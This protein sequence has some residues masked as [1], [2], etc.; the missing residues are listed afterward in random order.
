MISAPVRVAGGVEIRLGRI[1]HG[2]VPRKLTVS[3][4]TVCVGA[5]DIA[6][7]RR[8]FGLLCRK[9]PMLCGTIEVAGDVCSLRVPEDGCAATA[10]VEGG[11]G[12]WLAPLD[13]ACGLAEL[14]IVRRGVRT[15]VVLR[16]SHAINDAT[17]GFALLEHFWRTVTALSTGGP[18][19]DP[20]V[21]HPHSLEAAFRARSMRLPELAMAAMGPAH[22]VA[23]SDTGVD[24][25]FA[26]RP[27]QRITLS[28]GDTGALL[29]RARASGTTLH[30]L[31]S[32]AIVGAER[33]MSAETV[34]GTAALP[35]IMFHLADLRAQLR[36]PASP[37]EITNALGFAPTVTACERT[38][39]LSVLAKQVKAQIVAGVAD[40]T[41]L[42][43]MLAA[44]TAAAQGRPRTGAGNFIT[45]WGVVPELPVPPGIEVVD[46]RGFATSES[47][48]W[49]G[50]FVST[51][52]GR[53][54]IELAFSAR[55]HRLAQIVELRENVV[56][57]L[58]RLA[59]R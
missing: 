26:P 49:I 19:P 27:E 55:F 16:V 44:A 18:H 37:D 1:D 13:P 12:D 46:F 35:M 43:V 5:V 42:A 10:F 30:A 36:P 39:D 6:L 17:M 59:H 41:A 40:G 50:Y 48:G 29:A 45:N 20:T 15:E 51:F 38:C 47:V 52:A 57:N 24:A 31:L 21:I 25:V 14:T 54:S 2:F 23:A 3:Y 56:A 32:A 58:A 11:V 28:Q 4:V 9:Y 34:G 8:A 33:A 53:L 22:S 7:L